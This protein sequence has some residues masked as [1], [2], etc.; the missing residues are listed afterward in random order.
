MGLQRRLDTYQKQFLI[1]SGALSEGPKTGRIQGNMH[2]RRQSIVAALGATL[3]PLHIA[4]AAVMIDVESPTIA[5]LGTQITVRGLAPSQAAH[6]SVQPPS[7]PASGEASEAILLPIEGSA[8][9]E[10]RQ[11]L[12]G[13][14]MQR[15]GS[16]AVR[17][18]AD[19]RTIAG[20]KTFEVLPDSVDIRR[21]TIQALR[22]TITP[23]GRDTVDLVVQLSD[24]YLNPLPG[25]PVTLI[26]S[27]TN[28]DIVALA[29]QTDR[30]GELRF[31][32]STE[33]PGDISL[34]ALDLLS[35]NVLT[36]VAIVRAGS[37]AVGGDHRSIVYPYPPPTEP[38]RTAGTSRESSAFKPRFY[39]AQVAPFDVI[40]GFEITAPEILPAGEEAPRIIVR[41][42]DRQGRTVEDYMGTVVFS[43][44]DPGASL[45]N[46]GRYTF[47][48][49][50][51][52]QKEFPLVLKFERG[53]P[54]TFRVEDLN[55]P[56]IAGDV[57][58][59]VEGSSMHSANPIVVTSHT[60]GD[61]VNTTNI[62]IEGKG[63]KFANLIVMGGQVD[64]PGA[65]DKDGNFSIPVQLNQ[66]KREFTIRVRDDAGRNDSGPIDLILDTE[67][68][69]IG[70]ITFSPER[71]KTGERVLIV[72]QSEPSLTS[73]TMR[74]RPG[75]ETIPLAENS[76][77]SGSYQAFF[78]AP[79]EGAYQPVITAEDRAG[80]T[81][82]VRTTFTVGIATLP[83]VQNVR[84]EARM[85]AAALAWDPISETV[86][87]YRVYVGERPD[88]FLYT[89][90]TGRP[91]TKATVAGLTPG[92]TYFFA[93]TAVQGRKE[94][95]EKSDVL[96]LEI[97][98]LVLKVTEGEQKLLLEWV[99]PKVPL[100]SYTLEYGVEAGMYTEK[101]VIAAKKSDN[102]QPQAHTLGDLLNGVTYHLRLTPTTI[103][104]DALL[105]LAATGR[106][107]PHGGAGFTAA[108]N[109]PIPFD[110][111]KVALKHTPTTTSS[112]L[113]S[114]LWFT[115]AIL[116]LGFCAYQ[117]H[118]RRLIRQ[119]LSFLASIQSHHGS[120]QR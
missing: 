54:Q 85:G 35:G 30:N 8:Q 74:L 38:L 69:L 65:T 107:T 41:A 102:G 27:R 88:N 2:I 66:S 94:S 114:S 77:S 10:A 42:V 25:R 12:R 109:D 62:T 106:G 99:P 67:D 98:G 97:P 22:R 15:A 1:I 50:D 92:R 3:L 26:S 16:Y 46:F 44:T 36:E 112:G 89:L 39:Y 119:T 108:P 87:Q 47:R 24:R 56:S 19:G 29:Q 104:G 90:D 7:D 70:T 17:I 71:P 103:T 76:S 11:E 61:A 34:R 55:D 120:N 51:L 43:A 118:R 117:W 21:S 63:P 32:V 81:T 83:T 111:A 75:A 53:G 37:P 64:V 13:E 31:L 96:Q 48:E 105:D 73:V 5:G 33:K 78:P 57:T 23:D 52:G 20:P 110:P 113:F 91:T 79:E 115:V 82:D 9:G 45:P 49:R 84:G 95:A 100:T 80:N 14:E 58:I 68:P 6:I 28:D 59:T 72:V 18:E 93:V 101:R 60:S 86:E 116:T 4:A 40:D